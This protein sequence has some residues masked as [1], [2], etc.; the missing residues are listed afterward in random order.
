MP[1]LLVED[2]SKIINNKATEG[3]EDTEKKSMKK[4]GRMVQLGCPC[5]FFISIHHEGREKSQRI[6]KKNNSQ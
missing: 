6:T 2:P 3:T 4:T 1:S 5:G